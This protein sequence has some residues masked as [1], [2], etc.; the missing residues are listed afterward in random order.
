MLSKKY[1]DAID[2]MIDRTHMNCRYVAV[3]GN[4]SHGE[5]IELKKGEIVI[6]QWNHDSGIRVF[7]TSK[8]ATKYW[9]ENRVVAIV[10]AVDCDLWVD[11]EPTKGRFEPVKTRKTMTEK[12]SSNHKIPHYWGGQPITKGKYMRRPEFEKLVGMTAEK[13][14]D[15]LKPEHKEDGRNP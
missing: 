8:E 14:K 3:K 2:E 9:E 4:G 11:L 1:I 15:V 13:L 10:C 7:V 12:L 5:S 6:R